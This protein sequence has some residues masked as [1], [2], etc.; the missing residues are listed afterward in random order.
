MDVHA[1]TLTFLKL[2]NIKLSNK[3][4]KDAFFSGFLNF[5]LPSKGDGK[6]TNTEKL[7]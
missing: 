2:S 7:E 6:S 4:I 1:P 3:V 5:Y